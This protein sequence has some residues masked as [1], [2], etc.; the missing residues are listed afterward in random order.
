M[1]FLHSYEHRGTSAYSTDDKCSEILL[2]EQTV[3]KLEHLSRQ[4]RTLSILLELFVFLSR[5]FSV[6][7]VSRLKL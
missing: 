4:L 5:Y 2:E 3:E 1:S 7:F 6:L